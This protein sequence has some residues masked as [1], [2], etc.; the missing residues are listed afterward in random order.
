MK[1]SGPLSGETIKAP[2]LFAVEIFIY[3]FLGAIIM[4]MPPF[5]G[6]F[7]KAR[8]MAS[9]VRVHWE[10][11]DICSS[12]V[13]AFLIRWGLLIFARPAIGAIRNGTS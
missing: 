7:G 13:L 3:L 12:W 2:G 10:H 5:Q 8:V 6:I 9:W 1:C 11:Q 4:G